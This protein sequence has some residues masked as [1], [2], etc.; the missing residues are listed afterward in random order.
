MIINEK[1]I[2]VELFQ[3]INIS[4]VEIRV[5]LT[6][7]SQL[8]MIKFKELILKVNDDI[9]KYEKLNLIRSVEKV[10]CLE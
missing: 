3:N 1:N 6:D 9:K 4:K 7:I 5:V 10:E 2:N 8:E